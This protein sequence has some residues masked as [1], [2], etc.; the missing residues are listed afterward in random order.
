MSRRKDS[1]G[2]GLERLP[3]L[4]MTPEQW[5]RICKSLELCPRHGRIVELVLRDASDEEIAEAMSVAP[6][7][8]KTL[9][10]RIRD[11]TQAPTRMLLALRVLGE[12]IEMLGSDRPSRE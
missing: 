4:P 2:S 11:R 5:R 7:T 9:L 3:P 10:R 8:I 12:A 1:V 6:T